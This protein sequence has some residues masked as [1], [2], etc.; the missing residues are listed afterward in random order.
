VHHTQSFL[1]QQLLASLAPK[2]CSSSEQEPSPPKQED[3]HFQSWHNSNEVT[4]NEVTAVE[5]CETNRNLLKT[6]PDREG[7]RPKLVSTKPSLPNA[8]FLK[9]STRIVRE[10]S[11]MDSVHTSELDRQDE[12]DTPPKGDDRG[13]G[14]RTRRMDTKASAVQETPRQTKKENLRS[15]KEYAYFIILPDDPFRKRWDVLIAVIL[16]FTAVVTPY[17]IAMYDNDSL[18]YVLVDASIDFLFLID[19]GLNFFMG[20]YDINDDLVDQRRVITKSYLQTWFSIDLVSVLPINYM[21]GTGGNFNSLARITRLPKLYRLV[22]VF[23]L[24]R[25]M[26]VVRERN[27]LIKYVSDVFKIS[28]G[29]ERLVLFAIFSFLIMHIGSCFWIIQAKLSD[30]YFNTWLFA[31]AYI[32][33]T[34]FEVYIASF[35]FLV[36][37]ITTVGFGDIHGGTTQE[38]IMCI[39]FMFIGVI[40]FSFAIGSLSSIVQTIDSRESKLKD[41]LMTLN[42]IK[43]QYGLEPEIYRRLKMAL[44]YDHSRNSQG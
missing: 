44:K 26:K 10:D 19:I 1:K 15:L 9:Q 29:F 8:S 3:V 2:A 4:V 5:M 30:D 34:N 17:R 21:F 24:I 37:T 14:F 20:Y 18:T 35:Y 39:I 38:R 22:K 43:R 13:P 7:P 32:D 36:A 40:S 33:K 28:A 42:K 25:L 27:N 31:N 12:K 16:V 41:K 6:D 11:D 23:R